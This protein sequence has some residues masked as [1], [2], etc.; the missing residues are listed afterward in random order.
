[1]QQTPLHR[2]PTG[3]CYNCLRFAGCSASGA[4]E[5]TIDPQTLKKP[6][7]SSTNTACP[8]VASGKIE[9]LIFD[10]YPMSGKYTIKLYDDKYQLIDSLENDLIN[11]DTRDAGKYTVKVKD[12]HGCE[13][14]D[15]ISVFSDETP[16]HFQYTDSSY[17]WCDEVENGYIHIQASSRA[18]HNII[19][20]IN[21]SGTLDEVI[22]NDAS[23]HLSNLKAGIYSF[24]AVD[25]VGCKN[26]TT[27]KIINIHNDPKIKIDILDSLACETAHTE[28]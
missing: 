18:G 13:T 14:S 3:L 24:R 20:V 28:L 19:S 5:I 25:N 7:L 22:S 11:F 17:Q 2:F 8:G 10:G 4:V 1:M 15:T 9:G 26:D 23:A 27:I 16:V 21:T 6:E 12:I